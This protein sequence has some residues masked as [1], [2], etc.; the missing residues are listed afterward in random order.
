M[1]A[2]FT[3][4]LFLSI[5]A[6]NQT[7]KV[8][9]GAKQEKQTV[10][11][12]SKKPFPKPIGYVNDYYGLFSIEERQSLDELISD[13]EGKTTTQIAVVTLDSSYAGQTEFDD[14]SLS[15]AKAWGVGTKEKNNGILIAICPDYRRVRIQNGLGI[16]PYLSDAETMMILDSVIFPEFRKTNYYKGIRDGILSII[17]KLHDAGLK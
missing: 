14:Y 5:V 10:N 6:C 15:L 11:D 7:A 13:Y 8:K 1:R 2:A 17:G 3:L 9:Q 12:S 16:D 4:L